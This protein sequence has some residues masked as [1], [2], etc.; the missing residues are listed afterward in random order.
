MPA[1]LSATIPAHRLVLDLWQ[2]RISR[3]RPSVRQ[4][5][6]QIARNSATVGEALARLEDEIKCRRESGANVGAL[7]KEAE[8]LREREPK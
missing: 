2:Y 5:L 6:T 4:Y 1:T 3:A 7:E 8:W